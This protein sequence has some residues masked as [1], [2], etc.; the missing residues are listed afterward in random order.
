M[1]YQNPKKLL[2]MNCRKIRY[3]VLLFGIILMSY[4]L[5]EDYEN[6]NLL[7][8]QL[9]FGLWNIFPHVV[10]LTM[11]RNVKSKL[12]LIIPAF[13]LCSLQLLFIVDYFYSSSS[14]SGLIFIFAPIYEL[15]FMVIGFY[16]AHKIHKFC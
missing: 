10:Y 12:I 6:T 14:T 11:T 4:V 5:A 3:G 9:L 13:F 16:L 7:F 8:G 2:M 15:I 1:N